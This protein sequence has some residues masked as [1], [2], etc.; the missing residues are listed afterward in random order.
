MKPVPQKH[1]KLP[2]LRFSTLTVAEAY[3]HFVQ[4][5][6]PSEAFL[7]IFCI[8]R[9]EISSNPLSTTWVSEVG[10]KGGIHSKN[11]VNP[12]ESVVIESILLPP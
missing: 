11:N 5:C 10:V 6:P 12:V 2:V 4:N 1:W 3:K 8:F 9:N 7:A